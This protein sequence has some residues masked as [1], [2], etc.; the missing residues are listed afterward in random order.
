MK[1]DP[2]EAEKVDLLTIMLKDPLFENNDEQIINESMTFFFAGTLTQATS[3][4]NIICYQLQYPQVEKKVRASLAKNFT[5]FNNP[6]ETLEQLAEQLSIESL[7]L[8]EDDYLKNVIYETMR[9]EP[10][11]PQSTSFCVTEDLDIGGVKVLANDMMMANIYKLHHLEDQWG[12]DHNEFKPERFEGRGKHNPMSFMPFLAGKR[13][14][15]GKTFAEN[16][17]KVV[18]PLIMKAFPKMEY[19]NREF[20]QK[21]P[22]NNVALQ[23]K[24]E[25]LLKLHF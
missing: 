14:C 21:K 17:L 10:P 6:M 1:K 15:A 24:P 2:K 16:S 9:I 12:K 5:S 7:D 11:V 23:K 4:A 13:V 3:T 22:T 25:I 8:N 18:I 19:V 20:Y